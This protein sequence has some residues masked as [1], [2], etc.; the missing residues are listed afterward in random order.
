MENKTDYSKFYIS[1]I[2]ILSIFLITITAID[3]RGEIEYLEHLEKDLEFAKETGEFIVYMAEVINYC[4]NLS[5]L[6]N[7][8]LLTNFLQYKADEIIGEFASEA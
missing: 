8:E 4:A 3:I 1:I 5:N 7:E 2:I 6:S